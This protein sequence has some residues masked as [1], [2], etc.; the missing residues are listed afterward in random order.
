MASL[1]VIAGPMFAGKSW[2][3]LRHIEREKLA[4]KRVVALKPR[5]DDRDKGEIVAWTWD[6]EKKKFIV[7]KRYPAL[8]VGN[9]KEAFAVINTKYPQVLVFDEAQFFGAPK[10]GGTIWDPWF[11]ELVDELLR[12]GRDLKM[13]AGGLDM[14]AWGRPFGLMPELMAIGEVQKIKAICFRCKSEDAAMT[15]K[16]DKGTGLVQTG[17]F[18]I[19]EALCRRCWTPPPER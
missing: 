15:Y 13:V 3:L 4:G 19:Y 2:E 1:L 7:A 9:R 16:L 10:K 5:Q 18:G 11:Y 12:S 6:E 14:D 8:V 17:K